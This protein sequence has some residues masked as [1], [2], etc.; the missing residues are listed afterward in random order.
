MSKSELNKASTGFINGSPPA[1]SRHQHAC[2]TLNWSDRIRL[3]QFPAAITDAVRQAIL[4]SWNGGLQKEK[5]YGGAHE[6]KLGGNPWSGQGME[7]VE[8]RI[9]MYVFIQLT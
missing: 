5:Q 3:I 4:I 6:F 1:Y 7:A 9:L 8:S 2:L